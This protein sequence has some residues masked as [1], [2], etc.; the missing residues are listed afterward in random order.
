MRADDVHGSRVRSNDAHGN[1]TR[2]GH[3]RQGSHHGTRGASG[4][5]APLAPAALLTALAVAPA[6][7]ALPG[8]PMTLAG[9]GAWLGW[10]GS[11]LI[12]ASLLLMVREPGLAAWFGDLERMYRWHHGMGTLGYAVLLA[13]P[14]VLAAAS[15]PAGPAAAWRVLSPAAQSWH[16]LL[17]WLALLALMAGLGATFAVRLRYS[18]WRPLHAT[19]G[20]GVLLGLAHAVAIDGVTAKSMLAVAA[21]VIALGWRATRADRGG[22]A[23]PYE[24]SAVDHPAP[25]TTE[26]TLRPLAAPITV[27]PGQFVMAAF[28]DGPHFRGCGEYHPY[29]V[30][31]VA[32]GGTLALGIKALGDCTRN[33]QSIRTGVAA[34]V[35][36]AYG[37]FLLNRAEAPELWIAAGIG[38][39]PFL[40]LL[41]AQPVTRSTE[42]FYAFRS[43]ENAPYLAELAGLAAAQPRLHAHFLAMQEDTE[44][45]YALLA[46]VSDLTDREVYMCGPPPLVDALGDWLRRRGVPPQHVHHERFDFR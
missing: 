37:S 43:A 3:D 13:H 25:L 7:I 15:L 45:L 5:R 40:A 20:I 1:R 46:R 32:P 8:T 22:G 21:A 30:S 26:V 27:A 11:G 35:Q 28:F 33:I 19:L 39:T 10:L 34:R 41:R 4:M 16:T 6:M 17:G 24:V 18:L 14:V 31:A 42:F 36:G 23:C 38:V 12:A 9:A 29:T 2:R 44:P